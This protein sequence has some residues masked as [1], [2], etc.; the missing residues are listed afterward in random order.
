[1]VG[2]AIVEGFGLLMIVP[3]AAIALGEESRLP[4]WMV[5]PFA[6]V[7]TSDRLILAILLF[8]A[9][10]AARAILLFWRDTLRARL[11]SGYQASLQLR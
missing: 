11:Q 1:M 7:A 6:A 8:L 2:A 3:L 4:Q 10:M 5:D 9:A